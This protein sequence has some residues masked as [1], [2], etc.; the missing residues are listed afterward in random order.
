MQEEARRNAVSSVNNAS[1]VV[2]APNI[3]INSNGGSVNGEDIKKA[4]N[5]G[6]AEFKS[7]MDRYVKEQRRL[8]Y[9]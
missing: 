1:N 4:I 6:Y 8:S 2:Y 3:V 5:N 9:A 7:F